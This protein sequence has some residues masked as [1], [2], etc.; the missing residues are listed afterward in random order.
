MSIDF[1]LLTFV[2]C[3]RN[4]MLSKMRS[5]MDKKGFVSD[6]ID[7]KFKVGMVIDVSQSILSTGIIPGN[8][9][10]TSLSILIFH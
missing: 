4:D 7:D 10:I 5:V 9:L 2:I 1:L 3:K 6:N 8:F